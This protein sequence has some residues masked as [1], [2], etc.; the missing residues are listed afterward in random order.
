MKTALVT[1]GANGIGKE[2]VKLLEKEYTTY[3]WDVAVKKEKELVKKVDLTNSKEIK[4]VS[5]EIKK[6]DLLVL[7]AGIMRRG[8]LYV[9]EEIYDQV[10]NINLKG[11]WLTFKH[12]GDKITKDTTIVVMS[13]RHGIIPP[14]TPAI[15][16]LSKAGISYL[17]DLI[18]V[19]K[20]CEVKKVFAGPTDTAVSK[21]DLT[22]EE[23]KKRVLEKP[24]VLAKRIYELIRTDK[25]ELVYSEKG[26][27]YN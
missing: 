21:A 3:V 6:L 15:Y 13:S 11:Q 1:G 20:K 8:D 2:L 17:A 12:L 10:M 19:T 25:K 5:K 27:Y 14:V 23:Y 24:E 18:R 16:G 26:Y 22:E 4:K 7:N 9:D